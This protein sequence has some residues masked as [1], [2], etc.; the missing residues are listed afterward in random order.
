[1]LSPVTWLKYCRYGVKHYPINKPIIHRTFLDRGVVLQKYWRWYVCQNANWTNFSERK[2]DE[3]RGRFHPRPPSS[4][5]FIHFHSFPFNYIFSCILSIS[6]HFNP[7]SF[8]SVHF[9]RVHSLSL[10]SIQLHFL[11]SIYNH[12][13]HFYPFPS[14]SC[15]RN[16]YHFTH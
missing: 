6:I 12:S 1:M 3:G 10:I 7:I 11:P 16:Y 4:I 8:I 5:H 15:P 9:I 14:I 13:T 2:E